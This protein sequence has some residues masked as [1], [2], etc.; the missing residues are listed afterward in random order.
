MYYVLTVHLFHPLKP[1]YNKGGAMPSILEF[2]PDR[3]FDFISMSNADLV[4]RMGEDKIKDIIIDVLCGDN[5]R[6]ATEPLTRHRIATLNAAILVTMARASTKMTAQEMLEQAHKD[7]E[8]IPDN[9]PRSTILRWLIGLNKK[10]VQNILRS[11]QDAWND[12]LNS[13]I[14]ILENAAEISEQNYGLLNLE[15][16]L[17]NLVTKFDWFWTHSLMTTIGTHTLA[18]RGAE[19][20]LYGK[21]FEKAILGSVLS[22]LGFS[23]DEKRLG[24]S[25]TF[26]LSERGE[27]RESDATAII[28]PGQGVRFDVGFIG[29]GNT[30]IT[31]DKASRFERISQI[32]DQKFSMATIIII[33]RVGSNSS[34]ID[35]ARDIGAQIIQMSSSFWVKTLDQTLHRLFRNYTRKFTADTDK[36]EIRNA[37]FRC[38]TS[39]E[40]RI[41]FQSK[42]SGEQKAN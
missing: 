6:A 13:A 33:D 3:S 30:E 25:M 29:P 21:Y 5:V 2:I 1:F 18:T 40:L 9:D 39:S 17:D 8:T 34:V 22:V 23:Y 19:K 37:V 38:L 42:N 26:W 35:Q 12:Y 32:A 28:N 36:G 14:R 27:K 41:F 4:D 31:L 20:S 7:M 11:D 15:I 16:V 10:Q 24:T